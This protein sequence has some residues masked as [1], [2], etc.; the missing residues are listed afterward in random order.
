MFENFHHLEINLALELYMQ[1]FG[2]S[3]MQ[4]YTELELK[5][6]LYFMRDLLDPKMLPVE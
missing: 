5:M 1:F 6:A 3:L 4:K 2:K